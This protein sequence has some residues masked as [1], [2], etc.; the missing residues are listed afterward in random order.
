MPLDRF[1]IETNAN[2]A[3]CQALILLVLGLTNPEDYR[4]L[5][6]S[7]GPRL[8]IHSIGEGAVNGVPP[9]L[10]RS[11]PRFG[12]GGHSRRSTDRRSSRRTIACILVVLAVALVANAWPL[13][14]ARV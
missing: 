7:G 11:F 3:Q 6:A 5:P 4:S 1:T 2:D 10:L 14:S 8:P 9:M 12:C 13:E